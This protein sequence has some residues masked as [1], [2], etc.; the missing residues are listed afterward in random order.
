MKLGQF[1]D[2]VFYLYVAGAVVAS[3]SF[4]QVVAGSNR[5]FKI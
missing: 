5:L 1:K 4:T 3:W 2:P